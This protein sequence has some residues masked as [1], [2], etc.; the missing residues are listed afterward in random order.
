MKFEIS[1]IGIAYSPYTVKEDCPVQGMAQPL[2]K[3]S[4]EVFPEFAEG[5]DTIDMFSHIILFYVFDRAS[6][7]SL[8]RIPFL[9]DNPHGIFATRHPCR[10]NKIGISIVA[11]DKKVDATLEVSEMDILDG[12]PIIDIKP[13][14]PLFDL[15]P[16]A[17]NG[18][19]KEFRNKPHG[20]E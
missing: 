8:V 1:Q 11:L 9:D 18:W 19:I 4:V 12:T 16:Q 3:G 15:R 20:R 5:L 6:E 14:V 7:V 17:S 10:P 2:G 13:Y